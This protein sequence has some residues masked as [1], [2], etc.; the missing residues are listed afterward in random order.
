MFPT[1]IKIL[2]RNYGVVMSRK[3]LFNGNAIRFNFVPSV[4]MFGRQQRKIYFFLASKRRS[5]QL[6]VFARKNDS[7]PQEVSDVIRLL[8]RSIDTKHY[9]LI[10]NRILWIPALIFAEKIKI[11]N[12]SLLDAEHTST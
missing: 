7:I 2:Y 11:R 9:R 1:I 12:N 3:I 4:D 6:K 5:D 10:S 8:H